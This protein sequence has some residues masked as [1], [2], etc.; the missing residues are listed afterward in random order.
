LDRAF[1][2]TCE[3]GGSKKAVIFTESVRTQTWLAELLEGNGYQGQVVLLNGSNNDA[4]SKKI[5]RSWMDKHK[6]S[7]RISGSKTADMKAALVDKF[8]DDATLIICTEAGAEGIN[9]QFCSLLVN[10]DLPWN[11]QRVE[12]RIGRVH[13]YGQKHDVV[14]VNFINKGNRADERV[15][16]LLSQKFQLFEGVFGASDEILGSIE[17]GVDIERRI[18]NIY[19]NCRSDEQIESEFNELQ[20]QLKEQL[21]VKVKETRKYLFEHFDADVIERLNTRRSKVTNQLSNYQ[22]QLLLFATMVL[23]KHSSKFTALENSFNWN[24]KIYHLNWQNAEISAQQF[25]RLTK[26]LGASLVQKIKQQQLVP[27]NLVFTYQPE[28]GQ[29]VDVK[30]LIDHKGILKVV[31]V[32]IGSSEEAREKILLLAQTEEN[33]TIHPETVERLL[34]LP[35]LK[36]ALACEPVDCSGLESEELGLL[37]IFRDEVEHDNE[38]YYNEEVEKLERWAEDKRVAL[39][40]SIKQLDQD[41]KQARKSARQLRTLQEKMAAKRA[42]KS[43]EKE[44][45]QVMLSYHEEK[46]LIE[47]EE[48]NLLEQIE[49][50]LTTDTVVNVLFEATW[51]LQE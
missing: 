46:K 24:G 37:Q 51:D 41:I 4:S 2:K 3:L 42:L 28:E 25:F 14:V 50:K 30:N 7:S 9:L 34:K 13:R 1:E 32:S 16:E 47:Q 27:A 31:K 36:E 11:P 19:Q 22:Q 17:S 18:H 48:D 29:W 33:E 44:R 10:Y 6:G 26:G 40:I 5:Y 21:E 43:L 12:Q 15:F 38:L 35:L 45:D 39:D 20:E 8:R 23:S 49:A